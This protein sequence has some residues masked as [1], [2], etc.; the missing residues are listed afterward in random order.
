MMNLYYF[1]L[2][3]VILTIVHMYVFS[4]KNRQLDTILYVIDIAVIGSIFYWYS[5][6]NRY[7]RVE[8]EKTKKNMPMRWDP[9]LKSIFRQRNDEA[10]LELFLRQTT[11]VQPYKPDQRFPY[12]NKTAEE[13]LQQLTAYNNL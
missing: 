10:N 1:I 13:A 12:S 3:A 9:V 7:M 8:K 5:T 6:Y 4:L 2:F 11:P